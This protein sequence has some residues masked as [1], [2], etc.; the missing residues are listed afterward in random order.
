[1]KARTVIKVNVDRSA[2]VR[3]GARVEH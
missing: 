3:H 1:L 2:D